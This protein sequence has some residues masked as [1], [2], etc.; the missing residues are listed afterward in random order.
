MARLSGSTLASPMVLSLILGT[1]VRTAVGVSASAV[2]GVKAASR[3]FIRMGIVVLGLQLS[4]AQLTRLGYVS[5]VI[6]V[7]TLLATFFW[8]LW[9]GACLR[10]DARLARLIAAGTSIC[11][12]SA[13]VAANTVAGAT[14]EDVAYAVATVSF[15]G[16]IA[17][18]AYPVVAHV[19]PLTTEAYGLWAGASIHEVGQVAAAAQA[20]TGATEIATIAKLS[21]VALLAPM[22][23]LLGAMSAR[24]EVGSV[25][26]KV[27]FPWFLLGF[28]ALICVSSAGLVSAAY[29]AE[30][31]KVAVVLLTLGLAALGL[32]VDL[33]RLRLRGWRP[34]LLAAAAF[35]FI[36]GTSLSSILVWQSTR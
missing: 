32:D 20:R 25:A 14:E 8:T 35:V 11:G 15:F 3:T 24:H 5:V 28:L 9:L 22:V 4:I 2:P 7:G 34:L 26:A 10:V 18:F 33:R 21:R 16:T 17:V 19:L 29:T 12:A 23:L 36:A 30:S 6:V 27:E 31:G 13:V 1:G